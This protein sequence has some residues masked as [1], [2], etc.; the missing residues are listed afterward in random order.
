MSDLCSDK[1][2]INILHKPDVNPSHLLLNRDCFFLNAPET[3][4]TIQTND[5]CLSIDNETLA[6]YA[7]PMTLS[8]RIQ[9]QVKFH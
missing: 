4:I 9:S 5:I 2:L 1:S 3:E 7:V 6:L 8:V